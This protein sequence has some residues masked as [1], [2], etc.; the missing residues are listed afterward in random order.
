MYA[1]KQGSSSCDLNGI[2]NNRSAFNNAFNNN[3]TEFNVSLAG[4][5]LPIFHSIRFL[6]QLGLIVIQRPP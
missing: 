3:L 2:K 6:D 1:G 4:A 5:S